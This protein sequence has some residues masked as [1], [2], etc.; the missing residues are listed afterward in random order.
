MTNYRIDRLDGFKMVTSGGVE[1]PRVATEFEKQMFDEVGKLRRKCEALEQ[2]RPVW[3][4][5]EVGGQ[6]AH[7]A[8]A[9]LWEILG[10]D[11]QTQAC[12]NARELTERQDLGHD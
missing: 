3:T 10:A 8:L 2:L 12:I 9:Q 7:A 4:S 5:N 11:N 6:I 1:P